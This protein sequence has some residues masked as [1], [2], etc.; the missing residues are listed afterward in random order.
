MI[1]TIKLI[2]CSVLNR[3]YINI[4]EHQSTSSILFEVDSPAPGA[5]FYKDGSSSSILSSSIDRPN[6][7]ILWILLANEDGSSNENPDANKAVSNKSHIKSFTV[8]SLLSWSDFFL[9]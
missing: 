6:L 3:K 1:G 8:L 7:I 5:S 9:N 4:Y 2:A